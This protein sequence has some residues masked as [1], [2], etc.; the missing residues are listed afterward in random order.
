MD[1]SEHFER[2]YLGG[3]RSCIFVL[4]THY[5]KAQPSTSWTP[6]G[7]NIQRCCRGHGG[8]VVCLSQSMKQIKSDRV[9]RAL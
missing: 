6:A 1:R 2:D 9:V 3:K 8:A 7:L 5:L 4:N